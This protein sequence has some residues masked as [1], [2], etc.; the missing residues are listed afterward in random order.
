MNLAEFFKHEFS[1]GYFKLYDKNGSLIFNEKSNK[2]WERREYDENGNIIFYED[3]DKYWS[4]HEYDENGNKTFWEDSK[5][6]TYGTPKSK[7]VEMTVKEL[8]DLI[9][10]QKGINVKLKIKE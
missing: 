10:Q 5:E 6:N 3:S 2:Y 7:E 8:Q 1:K 4:R 9:S